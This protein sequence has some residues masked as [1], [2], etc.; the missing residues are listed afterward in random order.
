[1]HYWYLF[2]EVFY[3]ETYKLQIEKKKSK[4]YAPV[5]RKSDLKVVQTERS[6]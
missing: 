3:F 5:A 1:M 6:D 2:C 4:L